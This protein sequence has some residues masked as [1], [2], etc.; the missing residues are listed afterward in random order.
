MLT[1]DHRHASDSTSELDHGTVLCDK[2]KMKAGMADGAVQ[3]GRVSHDDGEGS[4]RRRRGGRWKDLRRIDGFAALDFTSTIGVFEG[5][6]S[7][8]VS[9]SVLESRLF[10]LASSV[11][12]TAG[13]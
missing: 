9:L 5:F 7:T 4:Q 11:L 2:V 8:T 1:F 12:V 3:A 6:G 13:H 10:G